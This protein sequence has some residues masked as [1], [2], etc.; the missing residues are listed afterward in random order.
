MRSISYPRY[1][2]SIA[3]MIAVLATLLAVV[4]H[5]F[6]PQ[7][8]LVLSSSA[9]NASYFL[10]PQ[11]GEAANAVRWVDQESFHYECEF[12][13][14]VNQGCAFYYMLSK[15]DASQGTNLRRYHKLTVKL[16]YTG[17]ARYIR[18]SIRDFDP[19]FSKL[20]DANSS[21]INT[22][23]L[24]PRDLAQPLTIGLNEL[25]V[26]EWW[27]T[28]YDMPRDYASVDLSNATAFSVDFIGDLAG[29]HDVR[30]DRLDFS[31][32]W[33]S[34]EDWYL[35]ILS[36]WIV[37]GFVYGSMRL[38]VLHEKYKQQRQRLKS[39]MER[40][41]ELISE[42]EKYQRLSTV[43]ALTGVLNRHGID[44]YIADVSARY[45]LVSIVLID[46]DHFKNINDERGHNIG[47]HVLQTIGT[48]LGSNTRDTDGL[49]RWGGEEFV[50]VCPGAPLT[51]AVEL[52]E[53]LRQLIKDAAF[54]K[55][56]SL[57]VTASFGVA[58]T[59]NNQSFE[60]AFKQADYA[61]YQA[62]HRGR[63]CVVAAK[64]EQLHTMTGAG[65]G[66]WAQ[67]SGRFKVLK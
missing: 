24:H 10:L 57:A 30:I 47:D 28:Q 2:P 38:V 53:K 39:L 1:F 20:E 29:H 43:D 51:A 15:D 22:I 16:R 23:N 62:K 17:A 42:K 11:D 58:S 44:Q 40:N 41:L 37:I 54:P 31:G 32:D 12:A 26:P 14:N 56:P 52:S 67:I 19:R 27:L 66:A 8:H 18:I 55:D 21:K 61:L 48:L 25:T 49:G 36:V 4:G 64:D 65:R 3:L 9:S 60:E 45:R 59:T 7:R 6:I 34:A 63:N 13:R 33:I 50:L 35:G 5:R 46:L